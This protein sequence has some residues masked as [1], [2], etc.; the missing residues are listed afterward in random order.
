MESLLDE[1]LIILNADVKDAEDCIRLMASSFEELGYVQPGYADAV[2]QREK[3]HPTGLPGKGINIAIPH[4]D[5]S[6]VNKPAVGVI[7]PCRPVE[8]SMMGMKETKLMCEVVIPLVVKDSKQQIA[9]LKKMM[10]VIQNSALL[11]Q[12]RNS[13]SKLEV[14]DCLS[15]LNKAK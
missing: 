8:F 4:T 5:N 9:M 15:I 12:I 14:I 11:K 2:I 6:L 7:V 10:E 13:T 1:R 3:T